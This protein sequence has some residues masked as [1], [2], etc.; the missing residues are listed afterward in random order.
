MLF[1]LTAL[2]S[3][4][5]HSKKQILDSL[6]CK[7]LVE[8]LDKLTLE[9]LQDILFTFGYQQCNIFSHKALTLIQPQLVPFLADYV[10]LVSFWNQGIYS[11]APAAPRLLPRPL[12]LL[13][14]AAAVVLCCVV[15]CCVVLCCVVLC[16][17]VLC[18]VVLCCVVLCCVVLCCVVLCCVV[19]CCVV[20]CC[21]V[22]CCVVVCC[23]VVWYGVVCWTWM[24]V[25]RKELLLN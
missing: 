5:G 1:G 6:S 23:V 12:S 14:D 4:S 13:S 15:L 2:G 10:G 19:L 3:S 9:Q 25:I 22:L 24:A 21:V 18:C 16:C 17:V 20:L 11:A 7:T 8:K